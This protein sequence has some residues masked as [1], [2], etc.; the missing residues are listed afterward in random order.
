MKI[1]RKISEVKKI[2]SNKEIALIPTMGAIHS[3][4]LSLIEKAKENGSFNIVSI[5]VN[6]IQFANKDEYKNY[7]SNINSDIEI[8]KKLKVDAIFVPQIKEMYPKGFS[9]NI[10]IG[11]IGNVLEGKFRPGHFS[12][13]ATIITKL[14]SIIRPDHAYFGQKDAQQCMVIKKL[15]NE[16]NLGVKIFITPTIRDNNG[17]A[18]SSRNKNLNESQLKAA[19]SLFKSLCLGKKL[20][21]KGIKNSKYIK[22]E[23]EKLIL[24]SE[25]AKIDYISIANFNNLEEIDEITPPTLISLAAWF[26]ETRLIDNILLK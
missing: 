20:F 12:G 13:V 2:Q 18:I 11:P 4:H 25:V 19:E 5:F 1:I 17:I 15:N 22:N 9:T 10:N 21:D 24:K 8:L 16:L 26:G 7:P 3:G 6:P 23:I 14:F